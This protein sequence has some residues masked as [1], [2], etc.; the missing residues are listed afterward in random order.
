MLFYLPLFLFKPEK[1]GGGGGA[2]FKSIVIFPVILYNA[3]VSSCKFSRT[4]LG[5][6]VVI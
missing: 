5:Q 2:L 1:K 3:L 6:A 4:K